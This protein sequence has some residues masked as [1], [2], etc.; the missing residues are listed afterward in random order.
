MMVRTQTQEVV[1]EQERGRKRKKQGEKE[2]A[3]ARV[4]KRNHAKYMQLKRYIAAQQ[5]RFQLKGEEKFLFS[6]S[7]LVVVVHFQFY[8][9]F[10]KGYNAQQIPSI[11]RS[12]RANIVQIYKYTRNRTE[13]KCANIK[14]QFH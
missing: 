10:V 11:P 1:K 14:R 4:K 12:G 6:F 9:R 7:F 8:F 13:K 3:R 5:R 2:R